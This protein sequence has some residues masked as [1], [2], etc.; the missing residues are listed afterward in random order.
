MDSNYVYMQASQEGDNFNNA[1]GEFWKGLFG[2]GGGSG[3]S[4]GDGQGGQQAAAA[5]MAILGL[6]TTWLGSRKAKKEA[7]AQEAARQQAAM[8][9][10]QNQQPK[11]NATLYVVGGLALVGVGV[12][13]FLAVR[14]K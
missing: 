6:A 14:K 11:S 4:G 1:D 5:G 12:A 2:G 8:Y 13:I 10:A 9:A 3:D 7:E